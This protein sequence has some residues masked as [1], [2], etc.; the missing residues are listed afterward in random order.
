MK[1]TQKKVDLPWGQNLFFLLVNSHVIWQFV[2][3]PETKPSELSL[4]FYLLLAVCIPLAD[5]ASKNQV[6]N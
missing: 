2:V 5:G 1:C 4:L 6:W 3:P